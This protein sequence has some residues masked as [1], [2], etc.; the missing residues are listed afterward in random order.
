VNSIPVINRDLSLIEN[1]LFPKK[2]NRVLASNFSQAVQASISGESNKY[3]IEVDC[4]ISLKSIPSNETPSFVQWIPIE[5]FNLILLPVNPPVHVPVPIVTIYDISIS[6]QRFTPSSQTYFEVFVSDSTKN[7][8]SPH[9][10]PAIVSNHSSSLTQSEVSHIVQ[11]G[12]EINFP[13]VFNL[14]I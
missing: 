11:S 9:L 2:W 7:F 10:Y 13:D 8:L 5:N 14:Y 6:T 4:Q 3:C 1:L 12:N